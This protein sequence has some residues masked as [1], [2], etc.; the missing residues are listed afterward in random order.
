MITLSQLHIYPIKSCAGIS[1]SEALVGPLGLALDRRWMLIDRA[2]NF[3]SQRTCARMATI[4]TALDGEFLTVTAPAMPALRLPL[5]L[6]AGTQIAVAVW[7]DRLFALDCGTVAHQWFSLYLG[8]DVRL[9]QFDPALRRVCSAQWTG[10]TDATVQFA[11]GFPLLVTNLASLQDLNVR[12][13]KKGAPPLPMD[14]FRPNLVLDGLDA[15]EEDYLDTLTLGAPGAGIVLQMVKPCARCEIPGIDQHTGWRDT[16]WPHEPL[17]TLAQYRADARVD[18][19]LTFGQNAVVLA[20]I[21]QLLQLGQTVQ[22]A[23]NF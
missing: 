2:G 22:P 16:Q 9:V 21:G 23:L 12:M 1:L 17:D 20:G 6:S 15:Y 19:G 3:L 7:Q 4:A 18:G 11:D 13:G 10:T 8:V 14:R 5:L